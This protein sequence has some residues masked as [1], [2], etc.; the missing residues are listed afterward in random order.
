MQDKNKNPLQLMKWEIAVK[1]SL[2]TYKIENFKE[3][4]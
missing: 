4:E 3:D 2:S 1:N